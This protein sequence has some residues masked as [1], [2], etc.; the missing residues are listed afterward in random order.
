MYLNDEGLPYKN[1][2]IRLSKMG[3]KFD[4]NGE[5]WQLDNTFTLNWSLYDELNLEKPLLEGCR[6][7]LAVFS[8]EMSANYVRNIFHYFKSLMLASDSKL[9]TVAT[10]QNYLAS[11][12][13]ESEYKL[14]Y[15][16]AFILDWHYRGNEGVSDDV[17]N[18]LNSIKLKGNLKGKAVSKS[19]PHSGAYNMNE[20]QA[21]L[22]WSVN[23]FMDNKLNLEEYTW[24]LLNMYLGFRPIQFRAIAAGDLIKKTK[25]NIE[26]Y[27]LNRPEAK[28]RDANFREIQTEIPIDEDLAL[29]IQNQANAS[30]KYIEN[31][32][33][34]KLTSDLVNIVPVFLNKNNI[35]KLNSISDFIN[36]QQNTPDFIFMNGISADVLMG[37]I[38]SKCQAKTERL[39]G[40]YIHLTSRRFRYTLGTNARRRGLSQ[41]EI[42]KILGHSDIQNVKVYVENTSENVDLIDEAMTSVLAP[43]AQAFAG[44]LIDSEKDAIRANDP[45]SRIKSLNGSGLGNCGEFGFCASGG[46]QCYTCTK[47]QPWIHGQHKKVLQSVN[48]ERKSLRERGASEFVIQSTDRLVLAI[49][50]VIQLCEKAKGNEVQI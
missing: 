38:S 1:G 48:E 50:Q 31:H 44:T 37:G 49:T 33:N 18:F 9:L 8:A 2:D 20:Q 22:E 19:C 24:L 14:G 6:K 25:N 47:F 15:L 23:A 17:V 30:V 5:K 21:I 45:R 26:S 34:E 46:R 16:R 39:D 35:Q 27:S 4:T 40:E 29:L 43:L 10:I 32:F 12:N 11:L 41:Y 28:Q 13:K 7:T 36:A 42:A 3:Y